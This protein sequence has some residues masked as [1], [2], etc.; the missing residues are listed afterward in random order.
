MS[1][2]YF[3]IMVKGLQTVT[4]EHT[5]TLIKAN[6]YNKTDGLDVFSIRLSLLQLFA[7]IFADSQIFH[8]LR[9]LYQRTKHDAY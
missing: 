7:F 5:Q 8:S 1:V 6:I 9:Q 3:E 4:Q 2:L